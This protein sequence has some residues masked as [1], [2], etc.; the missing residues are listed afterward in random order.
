MKN[1][2][3]GDHQLH[4]LIKFIMS[5]ETS[6]ASRCPPEILREIFVRLEKSD[7]KNVR[8]VCPLWS[9]WSNEFLF[10]RIWFSTL[11]QDVEVFRAW[12]ANAELAAV[13]KELRFDTRTLDDAMSLPD[14]IL[15]LWSHLCTTGCLDPEIKFDGSSRQVQEICYHA[16]FGRLLGPDKVF[17]WPAKYDGERLPAS[18]PFCDNFE[19][20]N[21]RWTHVTAPCF[22][23]YPIILQGYHEYCGQAQSA[24]AFQTKGDMLTVLRQGLQKLP[25]LKCID[26]VDLEDCLENGFDPLLLAPRDRSGPPSRRRRH[27]LHLPPKLHSVARSDLFP[28]NFLSRD[29]SLAKVFYARLSVLFQAISEMQTKLDR[30]KFGF[31]KWLD[32]SEEII[33]ALF[34]TKTSE[35]SPISTVLGRL[36]SFEFVDS[37]Y[38]LE[39]VCPQN[40]SFRALTACQNL[41]SLKMSAPYE[42][43]ILNPVIEQS[44]LPC[45]RRICL[46]K[47]TISSRTVEALSSHCQLERLELNFVRIIDTTSEPIL[48]KLSGVLAL[49][50]QV[51]IVHTGLHLQGDIGAR[52]EIELCATETWPRVKWLKK[53]EPQHVEL[54]DWSSSVMNR[55]PWQFDKGWVLP[56]SHAAAVKRMP[57]SQKWK[58]ELVAVMKKNGPASECRWHERVGVSSK[59]QME[60]A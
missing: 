6:S 29:F 5:T 47:G 2:H 11:P 15:K 4:L 56:S 7:L 49:I 33:P 44:S 36:T 54:G 8:S 12:T 34:N 42:M 24:L 21:C 39:S 30:L 13:V 52:V 60:A 59:D 3:I 58:E 26:L 17:S 57:R 22:L 25:N 51:H 38:W 53:S 19:D 20:C 50:P 9:R 23:K 48:T 35:M 46:F 37:W 32:S 16:R 18:H 45:L 55:K 31:I 43:K 41:K 10:D 28:E 14:Y 27:P 1:F 40:V